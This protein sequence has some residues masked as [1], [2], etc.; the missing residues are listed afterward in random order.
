[1]KKNC[2]LFFFSSGCGNRISVQELFQ[3][4]MVSK[5]VNIFLD[6]VVNEKTSSVFKGKF[7]AKNIPGLYLGSIAANFMFD[8][9]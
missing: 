5:L 7:H 9:L 6:E 4:D 2:A 1:M 3:L 8:W